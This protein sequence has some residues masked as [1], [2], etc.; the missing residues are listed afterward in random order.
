MLSQN[1]G[2]MD[3]IIRIVLGIILLGIAWQMML[4]WAGVIGVVVLLTGVLRWCGLYSLFGISTCKM[5]NK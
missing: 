3:R 5:E 2:T 4:W 1:V